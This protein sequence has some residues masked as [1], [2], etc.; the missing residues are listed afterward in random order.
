MNLVAETNRI[1]V[2]PWRPAEAEVLFGMRSDPQ[3]ARWMADTTPWCDRR[4]ADGAITSWQAELDTDPTLGTW[5]IVP[6][7]AGVAVGSVS[8]RPLPDGAGEVE[9]GW[10]LHPDA[11]GLG[12][13]REA[14]AAVLA[15]GRTL[16]LARIWALMWPGN[17]PSA[18]VCRAIGMQDLGVVADPWY[19]GDSHTFVVSISVL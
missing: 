13:A 4:Q 16:E 1:V 19:G 6:R 9:I 11:W 18:R 2:R 12:Y 15:H 17:A 8:L 5:A 3:V 14:A 7:T 10:V